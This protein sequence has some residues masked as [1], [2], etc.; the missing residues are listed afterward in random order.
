M[1][2]KKLSPVIIAI[3]VL[4]I[5]GTGSY[6][7]Y[8]STKKNTSILSQE[9][10]AESK[11]TPQN[12]T[13]KTPP[14]SGNPQPSPI[15]PKTIFGRVDAI[16]T[17]TITLQSETKGSKVIDGPTYTITLLKDTVI[18]KLVKNT[19]KT[20]GAPPVLPPVK[21]KKEDIKKGSYLQIFF[22]NQDEKALTGEA[23]AIYI[24][25]DEL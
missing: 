24:T 16:D 22:K 18:E 23:E 12:N 25:P 10:S 14:L 13:P 6:L 5:A 3:V 7:Y 15:T 9:N 4:V 17:D 20:L 11:T 1:D 2:I 21:A 8:S 19:S